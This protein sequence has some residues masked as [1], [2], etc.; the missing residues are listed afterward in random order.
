MDK[1][2]KQKLNNSS[3]FPSLYDIEWVEEKSK[4]LHDIPDP[5]PRKNVYV[6]VDGKKTGERDK[7]LWSFTR[8]NDIRL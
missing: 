8:K 3:V 2:L 6:Y 4:V 1:E 7:R 5:S